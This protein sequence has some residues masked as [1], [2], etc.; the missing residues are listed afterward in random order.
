MDGLWSGDAWMAAM[1][2]GDFSAA[3][4]ISDGV[5]AERRARGDTCWH[6]PRHRQFVWSGAPLARRRVLV[7]CYHGL[8]DTLQFIRFAA[9]LRRIAAHVAVWVQPALLPLVATASGVDV[10]LPLHD[11]TP[12]VGYDVDIEIMELAHALRVTPATLGPVPYLF[13]QRTTACLRSARSAEARAPRPRRIG[14]VWKAGGW[15]PERSIATDAMAALFARL[16]RRGIEP[17]VL[18]RGLAADDLAALPAR[19]I[20]SDDVVVTANRMRALD[21]IVSVDTMPAHL[22]GALGLP[23]VTLLRD[24]CDWRWMRGR[25][26]TPWYPTMR[27][28]RMPPDGGWADV[29]ARLETLLDDPDERSGN[30]RSE[31]TLAKRT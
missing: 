2:R 7:R 9:P 26:D 13:P 25:D 31:Q 24:D 6:W 15:D 17:L 4:S 19:D 20:G 22:A 10:V 21:L 29:L 27:L 12:D 5:L 11:G 3:W 23:C 28:V 1:R 30:H 16:A 14:F 8:G 18:Q